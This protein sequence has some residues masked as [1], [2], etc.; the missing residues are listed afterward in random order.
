MMHVMNADA[1]EN[2]KENPAHARQSLLPRSRR[3]TEPTALIP[4]CHAPGF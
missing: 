1:K 3:Y 4:N 2:P